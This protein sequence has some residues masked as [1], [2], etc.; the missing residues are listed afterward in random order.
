MDAGKISQ[1]GLKVLRDVV[2]G[3]S[4]GIGRRGQD[5][6]REGGRSGGTDFGWR[7]V[8]RHIDEVLESAYLR[9]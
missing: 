1:R 6:N 2:G 8:S 7:V 5:V 9:A 3:G 4:A